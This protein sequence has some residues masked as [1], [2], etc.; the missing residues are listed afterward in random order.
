MKKFIVQP[1]HGRVF[2]P[3][4]VPGTKVLVAL[5][6]DEI[7]LALAEECGIV[8]APAPEPEKPE[9]PVEKA[10]PKRASYPT[11]TKRVGGK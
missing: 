6:G 10:A 8:N 2:K 11:K 5:P 1:H 4:H 3:T 7:S 9:A